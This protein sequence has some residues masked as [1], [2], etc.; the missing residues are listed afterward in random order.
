MKATV[1][2]GFFVFGGAPPQSDRA[3]RSARMAISVKSLKL[4][5]RWLTGCSRNRFFTK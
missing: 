2:L 3:M 1:R 5:N 4:S